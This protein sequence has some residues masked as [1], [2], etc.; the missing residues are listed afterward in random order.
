MS[1][2]HSPSPDQ[3]GADART[4][5]AMGAVEIASTSIDARMVEVEKAVLDEEGGRRLEKIRRDL[6]LGSGSETGSSQDTGGDPGKKQ[7]G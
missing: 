2:P 3:P 6:R 1:S 7:S 5:R 4:A